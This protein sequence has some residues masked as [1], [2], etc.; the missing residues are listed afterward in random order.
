LKG[1]LVTRAP[2]HQLA[3]GA[4]GYFHPYET[5]HFESQGLKVERG[6]YDIVGACLK[7]RHSLTACLQSK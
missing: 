1:L 5:P 7:E 3:R 6:R 2:A 4:F